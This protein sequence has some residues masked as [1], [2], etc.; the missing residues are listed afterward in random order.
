MI[1]LLH[2]FDNSMT[3]PTNLLG[4]EK[5][6]RNLGEVESSEDSGKHLIFSRPKPKA[7][8]KPGVSRK[9]GTT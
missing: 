9:K 4:S 8:P 5:T 7:S 2:G 1:P 6:I 3:N